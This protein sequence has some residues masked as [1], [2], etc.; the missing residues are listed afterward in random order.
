MFN[1]N[2]SEKEFLSI[3]F[4]SWIEIDGFG[5]L[6]YRDTHEP[7]ITQ[8]RTVKLA[9]RD[10]DIPALICITHKNIMVDLNTQR[11]VKVMF[12]DGN[13]DNWDADNLVYKFEPALYCSKYPKYRIIPGHTRY[14]MNEK[15]HVMNL[16]SGQVLMPSYIKN[17]YVRVPIRHDCRLDA[18][19][20]GRLV[21]RC[22]ALTWLDYPA[23]VDK[24]DVNHL[25]GNKHDFA[26]SNI[27][28][29]TR[30]RN[31]THVVDYGLNTQAVPVVVWDTDTGT[32]TV[33]PSIA[34][35]VEETGITDTTL[36]KH[37]KMGKLFDSRWVIKLNDGS[38]W[39]DIQK[40][41]NQVIGAGIK[42]PV[43]ILY[44]DGKV[45]VADSATAAAQITGVK[46]PTVCY[47]VN[48]HPGWRGPEGFAFEHVVDTLAESAAERRKRVEEHVP[49]NASGILVIQNG[50]TTRYDLLNDAAKATNI[51]REALCWRVRHAMGSVDD[52]GISYVYEDLVERKL[53]EEKLLANPRA[54]MVTTPEGVEHIVLGI[55]SA[56][57]FSGLP[58]T[59]VRWRCQHPCGKGG[60]NDGWKFRYLNR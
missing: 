29:A 23:N 20:Y 58:S 31:V 41:E 3:P 49:K 57:N 15:G 11:N 43:R 55:S 50:T 17:A 21:H 6:R 24:L 26:K 59:T 4:L 56:S 14:A 1:W 36:G 60:C 32:K 47:R 46:F 9:G 33:H 52:R 10:F 53:A 22:L 25:N 27:E 45:R 42:T 39:P 48:N 38:P 51:T 8:G 44:P 7:I 13:E 19:Y 34:R 18:P 37:L 30:K 5:R 54:V 28:W 16:K 12:A 35:A 2:V 40:P